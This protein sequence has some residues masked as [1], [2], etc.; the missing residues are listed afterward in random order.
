M[1]LCTA[2]AGVGSKLAPLAAM[3]KTCV[4][5]VTA[6]LDLCRG[7]Q[8]VVR[9]AGSVELCQRFATVRM[10]RRSRVASAAVE[11]ETKPVVDLAGT[12]PGDCMELQNIAGRDASLTRPEKRLQFRW[13]DLGRAPLNDF[14]IRD[15][16]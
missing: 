8:V 16:I 4:A 11:R 6:I 9:R 12:G 2:V 13:A 10:D 7:R 1:A 3:G 15:E 5:I 14:P